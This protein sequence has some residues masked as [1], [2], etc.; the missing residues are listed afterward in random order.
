MIFLSENEKETKRD[1]INILNRLFIEEKMVINGGIFF[2]S[3]VTECMKTT[4]FDKY[5]PF[6]TFIYHCKTNRFVFHKKEL[7]ESEEYKDFD[8]EFRVRG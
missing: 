5:V 6:L 8:I 2:Y 4:K 3:T 1:T 7:I